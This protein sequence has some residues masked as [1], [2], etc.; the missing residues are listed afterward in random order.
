M[1]FKLHVQNMKKVYQIEG[2]Q[3]VY[4]HG[5]SVYNHLLR[6]IEQVKNSTPS[7]DE[8]KLKALLHYL[9]DNK[10]LRRYSIYHDIGKSVCIT[11]DEFG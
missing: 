9:Y 11:K 8:F 6:L 7:D 4:D 5:V 1:S 2:F 3:S 10:T